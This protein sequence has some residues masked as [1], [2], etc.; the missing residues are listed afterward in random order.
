MSKLKKGASLTIPVLL[1]SGLFKR[2]LIKYYSVTEI[3][4]LNEL[5]KYQA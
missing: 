3:P 1:K 2:S 4:L 5:N